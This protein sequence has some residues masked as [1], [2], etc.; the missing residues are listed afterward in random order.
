MIKSGYEHQI[1]K[2]FKHNFLFIGH[3][4]Y[5]CGNASFLHRFYA[6]RRQYELAMVHRNRFLAAVFA[7]RPHLVYI[8]G[9]LH[10]LQQ[11]FAVIIEYPSA[12]VL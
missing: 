10:D 4:S 1:F 8:F 6:L 9:I 11:I 12:N 2:N 5:L 3:F 7:K